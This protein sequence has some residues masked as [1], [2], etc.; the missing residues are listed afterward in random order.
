M[1]NICE[2]IPTTVAITSP[3]SSVTLVELG[4]PNLLSLMFAITSH[5]YPPC[6]TGIIT[7]YFEEEKKEKEKVVEREDFSKK[8]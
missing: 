7:C 4:T 6:R 3:I 8:M 2:N 1:E 5:Q